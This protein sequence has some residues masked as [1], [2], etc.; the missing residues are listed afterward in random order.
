M[1]LFFYAYFC[2]KITVSNYEDIST[3]SRHAAGVLQLS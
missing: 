1:N 2:T 3:F